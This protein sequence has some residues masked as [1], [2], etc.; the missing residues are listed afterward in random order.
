MAN[1]LP[2]PGQLVDGRYE[3]KTAIGAG[4]MGSVFKAVDIVLGRTIAIK[5]LHEHLDRKRFLREGKILSQ[6]SHPNIVAFYRFGLWHGKLPFMAM[7]YIEG[8]SLRAVLTESDRLPPA[9]CMAIGI[10]VCDALAAAHTAGIIHRDLKPDN[11]MLVSDDNDSC[12]VKVL[13]FGLAK[14]FAESLPADKLTGSGALIGSI[15]YMSPEQCLGKSTD[16]RSDIYSLGCVLYE[17]LSGHA[18]LVADSPIAMVHLHANQLPEPLQSTTGSIDM[19][20]KINAVLFKAMAKLPESRY[21]TI[22]QLRDD[23]ELLLKDRSDE[24]QIDEAMAAAMVSHRQGRTMLLP[25]LLLFSCLLASLIATIALKAPSRKALPTENASA[26]LSRQGIAG[27]LALIKKL[28]PNQRLA[29]LQNLVTR[30]GD[31]HRADSEAVE[32]YRMLAAELT[33]Q[34]KY[35]EAASYLQRCIKATKNSSSVDNLPDVLRLAQ[36]LLDANELPDAEVAFRTVIAESG[37]ER[38]QLNRKAYAGLALCLLNTSHFA[39]AAAAATAAAKYAPAATSAE[40]TSY[41]NDLV[42]DI[43]PVLAKSQLFS[44]E[45]AKSIATY[46]LLESIAERNSKENLHVIY[47]NACQDLHTAGLAEEGLKQLRRGIQFLHEKNLEAQCVNLELCLVTLHI[48]RQEYRS[49]EE[50]LKKVLTDTNNISP[51]DLVQSHVT[52]AEIYT[53]QKR[54]GDAELELGEAHRIINR[55]NLPSV[56]RPLLEIQVMEGSS[57]LYSTTGESSKLTQ[58]L[59]EAAKLADKVS[60]GL[61]YTVFRHAALAARQH[62]DFASESR[63]WQQLLSAL[64]T[65]AS[66]GTANSIFYQSLIQASIAS[67]SSHIEDIEKVRSQYQQALDK[68]KSVN[69]DLLIKHEL[70][71][72]YECVTEFDDTAPVTEL[73]NYYDSI[74]QMR[75]FSQPQDMQIA[76]KLLVC[77]A[78]G[79][80]F[81]KMQSVYQR[82]FAILPESSLSRLQA[83]IILAKN[84]KVNA[85]AVLHKAKAQLMSQTDLAV[86][87]MLDQ[88]LLLELNE[89]LKDKRYDEASRQCQVIRNRLGGEATESTTRLNLMQ[90]SLLADQGQ[91]TQAEHYLRLA[92]STS[93]NASEDSRC[94]IE[95]QMIDLRKKQGR[96]GE[97]IKLGEDV[98]KRFSTLNRREIADTHGR[99]GELYEETGNI[100]AALEHHKI[101]LSLFTQKR[102]LLG[103]DASNAIKIQQ[104]HITRLTEQSH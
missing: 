8:K 38:P 50:L 101:A 4:G 87:A 5:L 18:P 67:A 42:D 73:C 1:F 79:D 88:V 51:L 54:V 64:R 41:E 30:F 3:L 94:V 26:G 104:D 11:I 16:P 28:Q 59:A 6:L 23:L 53:N 43:L 7:E 60:P 55:S 69:P 44:G 80:Q 71:Y 86:P 90:A 19:P 34:H 84:P 37:P 10:Q 81:D 102:A 68:L 93:R 91:Y 66:S 2:T 52:L 17:L 13:D 97:A 78:M 29:A 35:K 45:T 92:Q 63:I 99:L 82:Y 31:N 15:H 62:V 103:A 48:Q 96:Y 12:L 47:R 65:S 58:T 95:L 36:C 57:R 85:L 40:F 56:A 39:A 24:I 22:G 27:N 70:G 75:L 33:A 74:L 46:S 76:T 83:E 77:L 89:L 72:C 100:P 9:R 21:Q 25:A 32:V 49:A 61:L 20:G 98:V 14:L